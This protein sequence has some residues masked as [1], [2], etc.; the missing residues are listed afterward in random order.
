MTIGAQSLLERLRRWRRPLP[1]A[2][3]RGAGRTLEVAGW[4][5]AIATPLELAIEHVAWGRTLGLAV[6]VAVPVVAAL[7]VL[8]SIR[9]VRHGPLRFWW[10]FLLAIA[11]FSVSFG[12]IIAPKGL[13]ILLV[14]L[15]GAATAF[16][17][18]AA[19]WRKHGYSAKRAV[20]AVVGGAG[21]LALAVALLLPGWAVHRQSHWAPQKVAPLDLPD[22][23][24]RGGF[25]VRTLTYGGGADRHR[26]EYGA[27]AAITTTSVNGEHLIDGWSGLDGWVRTKYWG[28][29][30]KALPR[31][32]RV[33]YPDG[34]G[35]FPLV[36][37][38]HGNHDMEDYSDGGYAYLGEL[39][40][41][42]GIIAVSVD[43]NFLNT[44]YADLLGGFPGGL[45]KENDARGW[46]LLEHLRLWREWNAD[47]KNPFHGKIDLDRIAL[48][49]HSRGGEAVAIA[50]AFNRLPYF[51]DD[52]R[53]AFDYGFHIR[54]VIAIAPSDAQYEPRNRPTDVVDV[55]Y[56]VIQ[57]SND[58]DVESFMG[59]AQYSRVSFD[60]C[61][62]CFKAGFYFVGANHGQFNTAWGRNDLGPGWG[63][64]L[65]LA[66]II[67]PT[68]Q[69][70]VAGA[71]F[72]AFLDVV[73][74]QR[75]DYLPFVRNPARGL[76]WLG[77]NVEFVNQFTAADEVVL[78]NYEEDDDLTTGSLP[79]V[80]ISATNLAR[81]YE[82]LVPLKWDDIDSEAALLAW[83]RD[84]ARPP[85]DYRIDV[86][87]GDLP[88]GT[89]S[90][91]LAMADVSPLDEGADWKPP[92]AID[93]HVVVS[94][95]TG[96]SAAIA[97]SDI[98]SLYP[99]IEVTTRKARWLDPVDA[100]EPVFQRYTIPLDRFT[101]VDAD[102]VA[103]IT[104]R[105]D[106]TNA[107]S[108]YLDDVAMGPRLP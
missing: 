56:L 88:D 87:D 18:G 108:L 90:F 40:A 16:G 57:G 26:A 37:M 102:D 1:A 47:P 74:K 71:L 59:S 106:V 2:A 6:A 93:F 72:D 61:A 52:S 8:L 20:A 76:A 82:V 65:N 31:Q 33:W 46:L 60:E 107:G 70:R 24:A 28:F 95:R 10:G 21:L 36:L 101:G 73:L 34:D 78:A 77:P 75:S 19:T 23:G 50:A 51:P 14:W 13:A 9:I 92:D 12:L 35:P 45:K 62:E 86:G 53:V 66:P 48:I 84:D 54:G 5:L 7:L 67:D 27:H 30:A 81:W 25:A 96:H 100:S 55:S 4:L 38:V 15:T 104:L 80:T 41:S 98:Q 85:P 68:A 43:E 64:V 63:H 29:D 69:R 105:F 22:P 39:F 91:A 103:S 11:A 94:D 79:D 44:G 58:G 42:R 83:N 97:L 32:G 3:W 89:L 17:A 99:P 49:G